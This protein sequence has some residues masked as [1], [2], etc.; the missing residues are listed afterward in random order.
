MKIAAG[1]WLGCVLPVRAIESVFEVRSYTWFTINLGFWL[2]A[3]LLMGAIVGAW[4]KKAVN[5]E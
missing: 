2:L 3:M 5:R 4:K 1:M